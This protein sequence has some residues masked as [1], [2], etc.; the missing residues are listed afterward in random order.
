MKRKIIAGICITVGIAF[1]AVPFY[2]HFHGQHETDRLI[3]Q[4]EENMEDDE[5]GTDGKTKEEKKEV[6]QTEKKNVADSKEKNSV[7]YGEEVVGIIEIDSIG[8]KYPIVEGC[9]SSDIAY[10][11]GHMPD[12]AGIGNKGNCVLCGHNGSRNGSFFTKLNKVKK[13]ERVR[14]TDI[15]GKEHFYEV[16]ETF[17]IQPYDN[18]VK[19]QTDDE[20]LTL[21]TCAEHGSKRYICKC[22]PIREGVCDDAT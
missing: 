13:G 10:A 21:L 16:S 6:L 4:F 2:Y 14:I 18:S 8:I 11:I 3:K 20:M 1:M 22:E 17:I 12:T 9:S 15:T 7:S 5:D 19:E